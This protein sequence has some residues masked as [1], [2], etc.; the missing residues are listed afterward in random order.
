MRVPSY[1]VSPSNPDNSVDWS[2]YY[3]ISGAGSVYYKNKTSY[4]M[5]YNLTVEPTLRFNGH[6]G[7]NVDVLHEGAESLLHH[8]EVV[9]VE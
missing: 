4:V 7:A 8:N 1:T 6:D 5:Q 3:P 2:R 9:G